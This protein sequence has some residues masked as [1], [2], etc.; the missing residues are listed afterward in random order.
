MAE[1]VEELG[2]VTHTALPTAVLNFPA[3]HAV[4]AFPSGPDD[5]ALHK[6]FVSAV[7]ASATVDESLGQLVQVA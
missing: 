5:P 4:H 3:A 2:Q 6:Q 1:C 7:L